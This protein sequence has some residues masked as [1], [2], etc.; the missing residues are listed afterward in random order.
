MQITRKLFRLAALMLL[1]VVN[2]LTISAQT[3]QPSPT[4]EERLKKQESKMVFPLVKGS[5]LSGVIP[6]E[7]ITSKPDP[8]K[9]VKLIFDFTQSTSTGKQATKINEGLEEVARILNLHIASGVKKEKLKA[10]IIFHSGSIL[11][12]LSNE[13]YQQ[14][15]QSNNPNLDMLGQ[16]NAAGVEMIICGQSLALRE[17]EH[18][19]LL[20]QVKIALA[21]KTTLTKYHGEGYFEFPIHAE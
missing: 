1:V 19:L 6:V 4:R 14:K 16:L 7:D 18:R 10:V 15:Y 12:V 20:P 3:T 13:F 2:T 8:A 21:A 9:Q 11:S 5:F 17:I